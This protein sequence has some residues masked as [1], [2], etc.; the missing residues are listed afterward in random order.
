MKLPDKVRN[1]L[2]NHWVHLAT[3]PLITLAVFGILLKMGAST[4]GAVVGSI[5]IHGIGEFFN[6]I[7][8]Y[9]EAKFTS[10]FLL[11]LGVDILA[12]AIIV[13]LFSS[14]WFVSPVI[15]IALGLGLHKYARP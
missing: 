5:T 4:S 1:V 12:S 6:K 7:R 14:L 3:K 13:L 9:P 2:N 10:G 8:Q 15:I 11:D